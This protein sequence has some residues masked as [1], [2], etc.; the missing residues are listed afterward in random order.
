M[1]IVTQNKWNATKYEQ[2]EMFQKFGA[3]EMLLKEVSH[4]SHLFAQ[5]K[6]QKYI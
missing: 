6:T 5:I 2:M 4:T 3:G 1:D